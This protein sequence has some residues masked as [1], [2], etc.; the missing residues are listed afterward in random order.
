MVVKSTYVDH[1]IYVH[2]LYDHVRGRRI[3]HSAG[4]LFFGWM[5]RNLV[6][7]CA[8]VTAR[9]D[10]VAVGSGG[11]CEMRK[12]GVPLESKPITNPLALW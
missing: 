9:T 10:S 6:L 1:R 5:A 3:R 2:R 7:V 8:R 12:K 4:Q 11:L